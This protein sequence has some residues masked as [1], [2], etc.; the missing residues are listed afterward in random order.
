MESIKNKKKIETY[1]K[2]GTMDERELQVEIG[3]I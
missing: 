2:V 1:R 3:A